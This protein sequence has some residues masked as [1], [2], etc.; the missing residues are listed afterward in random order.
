MIGLI[1]TRRLPRGKNSLVPSSVIVSAPL[2]AVRGPLLRVHSSKLVALRQ[3]TLLFFSIIRANGNEIGRHLLAATCFII[4][5]YYLEHPA[6]L[7]MY[8]EH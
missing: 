7:C 2:F 6:V 5:L 8:I 1:T 3:T 4:I